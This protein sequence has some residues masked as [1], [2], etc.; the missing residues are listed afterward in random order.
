M[1]GWG[2]QAG[3]RGQGAG[4]RGEKAPTIPLGF[5]PY[6]LVNRGILMG[7][8]IRK[9]FCSCLVLSLSPSPYLFDYLMPYFII[10]SKLRV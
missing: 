1:G 8:L 2:E 4:G 9:Y 10:C 5:K 7:I 3:G 6:L